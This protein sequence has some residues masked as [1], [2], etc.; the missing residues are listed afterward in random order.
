MRSVFQEESS[1]G[2]AIQKAWESLDNPNE[3]SVKILKHGEKNFL[4]FCKVPYTISLSVSNETTSSSSKNH[5]TENSSS[6]KNANEQKKDVDNK[7]RRDFVRPPR[8]HNDGSRE[9]RPSRFNDNK[10]KS[11]ES[12]QAKNER[13]KSSDELLVADDWNEILAQKAEKFLEESLQ[14]LGLGADSMSCN[15]E[16]NVLKVKVKMK[17]YNE[18]VDKQILISLAPI[19][20]QMVRKDST[21]PTKGLR[22]SIEILP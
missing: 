10:P 7:N 3:F 18:E 6:A 16:K 20:V 1:L 19:I 2:K 8:K 9:A 14:L 22:L 11:A 13:F 15:I 12:F 4:G 5:S 17:T 21:V